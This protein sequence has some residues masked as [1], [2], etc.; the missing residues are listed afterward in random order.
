MNLT[1]LRDRTGTIMS[2]TIQ[3]STAFGYTCSKLTL[4]HSPKIP[5]IRL[6]S[7]LPWRSE[8]RVVGICGSITLCSGAF[9]T[10][11]HFNSLIVASDNVPGHAGYRGP[12]EDLDF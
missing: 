4:F 2:I 10:N 6:A 11:F 1:E 7:G 12:P 8:R 5:Q 9:P 3:G